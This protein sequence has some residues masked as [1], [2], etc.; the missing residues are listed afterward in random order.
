MGLDDYGEHPARA[1]HARCSARGRT[2][3]SVAKRHKMH[4]E[5]P[6]DFASFTP[7]RGQGLNGVSSQRLDQRDACE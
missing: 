4:K 7:F 3:I 5:G 1:P 6:S 2:W